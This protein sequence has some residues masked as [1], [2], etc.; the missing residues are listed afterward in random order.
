MAH[1]NICIKSSHWDSA[2]RWNLSR[3]VSADEN[4]IRGR[5]CAQS[6]P[7]SLACRFSR[8][9]RRFY[10][11]VQRAPRLVPLF[12]VGAYTPQSMCGHH[13]PIQRGSLFCCMICHRSGHDDHPA[14]Q[15]PAS[16]QPSCNDKSCECPPTTGSN[17][18]CVFETRR[19]R[20]QRIFGEFRNLAKKRDSLVL[21]KIQPTK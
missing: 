4:V 20:R 12:P 19:Q 15:G 6:T 21:V 16:A 8:Q 7:L 14:L 18:K 11:D 5:V 10:R 3:N 13:E 9:S 17:G 2:G 1:N